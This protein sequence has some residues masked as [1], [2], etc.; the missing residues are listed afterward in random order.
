MKSSTD[1]CV[2][3]KES[4]E[5]SILHFSIS[6]CAR[7]LS[8]PLRSRV[9]G[10]L[11]RVWKNNLLSTCTDTFKRDSLVH[12]LLTLWSWR[13]WSWR[14]YWMGRVVWRD[15]FKC[16]IPICYLGHSH[17]NYS[18]RWHDLFIYHSLTPSSCRCWSGRLS[19]ERQ[20]VWRDALIWLVHM[21][22][23][24][25]SNMIHSHTWHV[26]FTDD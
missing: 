7:S 10:W 23:M 18:H 15:S 8:R 12:D 1:C 13:C 21:R 19:R 25:D 11:L 5:F 22:D 2:Y 14:L 24:A 4:V 9:F 6:F 26:S 16:L 17:K 20:I 3:E